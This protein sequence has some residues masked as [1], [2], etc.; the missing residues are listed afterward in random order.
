MSSPLEIQDKFE[1]ARNETDINVLKRKLEDIEEAINPY[2][3]PKKPRKHWKTCNKCNNN[4]A[5]RAKICPWCLDRKHERQTYNT[6]AVQ[7]AKAEEERKQAEA[8]KAKAL[9][10][11]RC[12]LCYRS[13]TDP[14]Y[15]KKMG[16]LLT[17][18]CGHNYHKKCSEKYGQL[19]NKRSV[20]DKN[21][22]F[23]HFP[24][25]T[26][27]NLGK[28]NEWLSNL[29][30]AKL[31][32]ESTKW[33]TK[34]GNL[35]KGQVFVAQNRIFT[36]MV[37][38]ILEIRRRNYPVPKHRTVIERDFLYRNTDRKITSWEHFSEEWA[39]RR[40]HINHLWAH[41]YRYQSG[42]DCNEKYLDGSKEL[43]MAYFEENG[44]ESG[45]NI[46]TQVIRALAPLPPPELAEKL[47]FKEINRKMCLNQSSLDL[48]L[49]ARATNKTYYYY[50]I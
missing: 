8:E 47:G 9:A 12:G 43:H 35:D 34:K 36:P 26:I 40:K 45:K 27:T 11:K 13:T 20:D 39:Q 44:I 21:T 2:V 49:R 46:A 14:A 10:L 33:I 24:K 16:G 41:F 48:K 32:R 18:S 7:E 6:R 30:D 38:Y 25:E 15:N 17:L 29:E 23:C 50:N 1:Q 22:C 5:N 31:V 37:K 4:I 19:V 3:V 42:Y 28:T